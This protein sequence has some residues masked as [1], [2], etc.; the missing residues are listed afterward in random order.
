LKKNSFIFS[1]VHYELVAKPLGARC[2]FEEVREKTKHQK[3]NVNFSLPNENESSHL[4]FRGHFVP[5]E[6]T[7][8]N[9]ANSLL[10]AL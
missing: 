7:I 1:Y 8:S 4:V 5:L 10:L 2:T 9:G 3:M 6:A